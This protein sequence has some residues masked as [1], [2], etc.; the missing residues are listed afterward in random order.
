MKVLV[1]GS[2][3]YIGR[4][5]VANLSIT[6]IEP[7]GHGI[8]YKT[9]FT[10]DVIGMTRS[11]T[12]QSHGAGE[13]IQHDL[14]APL[15]DRIIDQLQDVTHIYHTAAE[16]S[17]ARSIDNPV[18]TVSNN[19]MSTFHMLEAARKLKLEKFIFVS[20]G[21]VVGHIAEGEADENAPL[22]PSNPYSASKGAGEELCRAYHKCFSLP[23]VIARSMNVFGP[24]QKPPR[25]IPTACQTMMKNQ[26]VTCHVDKKV[27]TGVTLYAEGTM[28]PWCSI[29]SR[30]WM[31]IKDCTSALISLLLHS[32][33]GE[34]YHLVGPELNN[35][36]IVAELAA[37]LGISPKYSFAEPPPSH[38]MRYALRDTKLHLNLTEEYVREALRTTADSYRRAY[39]S[40]TPSV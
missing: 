6:K 31:P 32:T 39:E 4:H 33:V 37:G 16:V 5:L 38:D 14:Q 20:T 13:I 36:E 17:G 29:G 8:N 40:H 25:F 26:P 24:G 35:F 23:V 27:R 11:L 28:I 21:E 22:R 15:P 12:V 1:T 34:T 30:N 19:V 9:V 10:D 18:L 7:T 3:S 2:D